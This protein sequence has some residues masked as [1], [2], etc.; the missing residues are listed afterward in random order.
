MPICEKITP[1]G[2]VWFEIPT[3]IIPAGQNPNTKIPTSYNP[4]RYKIPTSTK[5]QQVIIP[6]ST[7]SQQTK[8]PAGQNPNKL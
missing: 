6:T 4:N 7:K 3:I 5:S 2:W 1:N 8:I